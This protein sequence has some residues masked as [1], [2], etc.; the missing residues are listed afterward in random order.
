M[1]QLSWPVLG[2]KLLEDMPS[3]S[4]FNCH[5]PIYT[6]IISVVTRVTQLVGGRA[7]LGIH[8]C[9]IPKSVF[10]L[11]SCLALPLEYKKKL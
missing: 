7:V 3:S 4:A 9:L 6:Y 10:I 1:Y 2:F 11:L 8:V 5:T